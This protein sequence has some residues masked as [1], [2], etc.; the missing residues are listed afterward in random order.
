VQKGGM[1]VARRTRLHFI[2]YHGMTSSIQRD[3]MPIMLPIC[4]T[5]VQGKYLCCP[6]CL[7]DRPFGMP[8]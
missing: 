8:V 5:N 7:H 3:A 2:T 4:Q 1:S 6:D